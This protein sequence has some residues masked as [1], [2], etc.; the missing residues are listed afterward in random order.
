MKI[1]IEK[2]PYYAIAGAMV[3]VS[4]FLYIAAAGNPNSWTWLF[5]TYL[6]EAL[7][8]ITLGFAGW[9]GYKKSAF[10]VF[11]MALVFIGNQIMNW[12]GL[13]MV[14]MTLTFGTWLLA[15]VQIGLVILFFTDTPI[16]YLDFQSEAWPYASNFLVLFFAIMKM[17]L[18]ASLN[19]PI[20]WFLW[21]GGI[22]LVSFGYL[23]RPKFAEGS[24]A[25]QILGLLLVVVSALG[26]QGS[27]LTL[28]P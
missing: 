20:M 10:T 26:I 13:A 15:I 23:L 7:L 12:S 28:V 11:V 1:S 27:G 8:F 2:I 14:G 17:Y 24:A 19:T 3:L 18:D 21:G 16:K 5:P 25:F 4:F 6:T 9:K 22:G